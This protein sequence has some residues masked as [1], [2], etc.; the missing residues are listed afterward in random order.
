M[1]D[2]VL[3]AHGGNDGQPMRLHWR[4]Q[5][6]PP[7]PAV[8]PVYWKEDRGAGADVALPLLPFYSHHAVIMAPAAAPFSLRGE[9]SI[10]STGA[11]RVT[12]PDRGD[13]PAL[14]TFCLSASNRARVD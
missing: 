5:L 6:A 14:N 2:Y 12:S 8:D 7:R 9:L 4:F 13:S 3:C 11:V 1:G 10:P